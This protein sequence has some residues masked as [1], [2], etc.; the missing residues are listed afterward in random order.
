MG[1][2][3]NERICREKDMDAAIYGSSFKMHPHFERASLGKKF[4]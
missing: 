4:S 3:L 2:T 1:K